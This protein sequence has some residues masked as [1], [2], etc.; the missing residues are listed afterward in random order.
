MNH[1]LCF[2]S[3]LSSFSVVTISLNCFIL[4]PGAPI[5]TAAVHG[6]KSGAVLG[7]SPTFTPVDLRR[8]LGQLGFVVY[9]LL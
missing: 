5:I 6:N 9:R 3:M 1:F 2:V 8:E 7:V 4:Y